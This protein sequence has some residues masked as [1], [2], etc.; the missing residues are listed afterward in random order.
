MTATTT[1][2]RRRTKAALGSWVGTTIE[3]YDY[4]CYGLAASIVFGDLFFPA[5]DPLVSTLLA[6]SSFAVGYLSRPLG[7]LIFGH[8]GDRL[9]RKTVLVATLVLMGFSTLAIGL[10]P[11]YE[12]IGIAAPVLL[13]IARILQ[14][15]SAGGEYGGAILMTVEHSGR[16]RRGFFGSLV[17]TGTTA[18]LLLANLVFLPVFAMDDEAMLAWGWRIPFL[19]S[20]LLVIVGLL[21]RLAVE[22]TPEFHEVKQD[23]AVHRLPVADLFRDHWRTV[24]LV[25]FA[26]VCAGTA[27]TMA[28]VYSLSYG[29]N[30]LGLSNDRMLSVLLP[31]TVV[32]LVCVP[33]FGRL[34]DRIG[35]RA[36]F[37]GGAASLVVLPFAW[38]ALL[39]TGEYG[40]MLLG[41][42]LLF[43]GYSANYAVVPAYF[44]AVFPSAIRYSGMSIA[45]TIGL[46][47]SNA[48]AP[49]LA[50]SLRSATGGWH[51]IA[52]YMAIVALISLAAGLF[53]R[54]PDESRAP[55]PAAR[56]AS[57]PP[58]S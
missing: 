1:A 6:L 50:T 40:W 44:S 13:I 12:S 30:G 47:G 5:D 31:A 28:T 23:R 20:A 38:F 35:I 21:V 27:F 55:R 37:L 11:D 45:F 33:L 2:A 49:A 14:G 25:A 19:L 57:V 32:V 48:I 53:L 16:E 46:I 8:Y 34:A 24:V 42:A 7:A 26:I 22:E 43:V 10:L 52:I 41:F 29:K 54:L 3:Y 56:T 15:V 39:D 17:N 51:A 18:G 58:G 4:A 9:G 36:V